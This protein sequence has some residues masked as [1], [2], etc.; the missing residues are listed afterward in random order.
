MKKAQA[1]NGLIHGIVYLIASIFTV[2]SLY[3]MVWMFFNSLKNNDEIFSSNIYGFPTNPRF[4][5]YI[6]AVTRYD[7]MMF[8]KNSAFVAVIT[9][10]F[11]IL[12]AILFSY[13][14][15]R[16]NWKASNFARLYGVMG[17]FIPLQIIIIPLVMI[18]KDLHIQ[19]TH[20]SIIL[21]NIA[22]N[23]PFVSMIFYSNFRS[24]PFEMEESAAIDGANIYVIFFRIILPMV[25][26]AIAT[27]VIIVF[28]NTW[29]ELFT[30]MI[31]ITEN[32]LKT[33]PLGLLYFQGEF[34]TDWGPSSAALA[35]ACLPPL[36][37]Y[38]IF[39]KQFEKALTVGSAIK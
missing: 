16:M 6:Q 5:N 23:L 26:P 9:V 28:L 7:M 13:A 8:F 29:N 15:A 18:A 27:A 37:L 4:E 32:R 36:I 25:K 39:G 10:V 14:T 34:A 24:I 35:I 19:N 30:A 20:L 12:L 11:T 21:P 3:P 22:F 33:L 31:M 1:K 38:L 17:M 2:A